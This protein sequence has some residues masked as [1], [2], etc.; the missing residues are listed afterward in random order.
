MFLTHSITLLTAF[1]TYFVHASGYSGIIDCVMVRISDRIPN[2]I[3]IC[4]ERAG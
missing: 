3:E 4:Q 2:N 1:T